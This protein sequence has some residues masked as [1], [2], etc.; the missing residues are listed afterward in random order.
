MS[1]QSSDRE[2]SKAVPSVTNRGSA[3]R[4]SSTSSQ[5]IASESGNQNQLG[6]AGG[7]AVTSKSN[8]KQPI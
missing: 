4:V 3:K 2:N 5:R 6:G 1:G 7:E 8:T